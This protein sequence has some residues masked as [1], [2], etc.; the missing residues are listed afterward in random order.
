MQYED[1][2][3][4][5]FLPDALAFLKRACGADSELLP[6]KALQI[7][8]SALGAILSPLLF[9]QAAASQTTCINCLGR[10]ETIWAGQLIRHE[11]RTKK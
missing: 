7:R 11:F 6:D 10:I 5:R 1:A 8:V 3:A 9:A 2:N 4:A